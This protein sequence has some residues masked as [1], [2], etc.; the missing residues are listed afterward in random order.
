MVP[1]SMGGRN[2]E[3]MSNELQSARPISHVY[4]FRHST[5]WSAVFPALIAHLCPVGLAGGSVYFGA[6]RWPGREAHPESWEFRHDQTDKCPPWATSW[7]GAGGPVCRWPVLT[8][9]LPPGAVLYRLSYSGMGGRG[10]VHP[11][12]VVG[13]EKEESVR[14]D[15]VPHNSIISRLNPHANLKRLEN[16]IICSPP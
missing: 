3:V 16:S 15:G 5:Y 2:R 4:L 8:R 13:R 7:R 6:F 14:G 9:H 10:A 12:Q 11:A 1:I